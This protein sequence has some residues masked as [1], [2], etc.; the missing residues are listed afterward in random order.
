MRLIDTGYNNAAMNMA[1]DEALLDS[2]E[3][4]LRFYRWKPAALSIGYFQSI[5][6]FNFE[7][8]KK[9]NI[10]LVRRITGGNAVL[11]YKEITYSFII[12]EKEMPKSVIESYRVISNGLLNGLRILG[13]K[14][15]MNEDV[16]KGETSAVCFNDPSWYEIVVNNK[17]MI[18]SAQKRINGRLLQ[19]GAILIDIDIEKYCSLFNNYNKNLIDKVKKRM[20]SINNELNK[21]IGYNDVKE[22][23]RKG[24]EDNFKIRLRED[25]LTKEELA[26]AKELSEK[27]YST[28][29][30]NRK[31]FIK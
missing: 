20:T 22:A 18:G 8:L 14:A 13:L 11:H 17:K 27:K 15:Q 2:K 24:F 30:W 7:N 29:E 28:K 12:D 25:R 19:H 5:K 4:I 10:D 9:Y 21:K 26:K 23:M 31:L 16:D 6:D 1:I 3:P